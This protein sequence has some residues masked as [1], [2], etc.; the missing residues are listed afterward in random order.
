[1]HSN[2]NLLFE[3]V[4]IQRLEQIEKRQ[5]LLHLSLIKTSNYDFFFRLMFG[6]SDI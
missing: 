4:Q 1:M 5:E 3:E 2:M 6:C